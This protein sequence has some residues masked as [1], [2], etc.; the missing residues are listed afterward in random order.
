M[1]RDFIQDYCNRLRWYSEESNAKEDVRTSSV[2]Q[3]FNKNKYRKKDLKM[4][5][6]LRM[7]G[8]E[9]RYCR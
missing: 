5:I 1:D 4:T 2:G 7:V 8:F 6:M 9:P 3:W